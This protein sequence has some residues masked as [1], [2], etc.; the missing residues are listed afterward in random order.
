MYEHGLGPADND[1][2]IPGGHISNKLGYGTQA[3]ANSP[4]GAIY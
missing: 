4:N 3:D 1:H 2:D